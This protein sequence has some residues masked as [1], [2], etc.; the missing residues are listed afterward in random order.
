MIQILGTLFTGGDAF[1][2]CADYNIT[3]LR[4]M[5][6]Q[7]SLTTHAL[8][9]E[10]RTLVTKNPANPDVVHQLFLSVRTINQF[11][12]LL[13]QE[14]LIIPGGGKYS[15]IVIGQNLIRDDPL[16]LSTG[17]RLLAINQRMCK[18]IEDVQRIKG[19]P[20]ADNGCG[21]RIFLRRE[22]L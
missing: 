21:G 5:D 8:S 15:F 7:L 2:H 9:L 6:F 20:L 18:R 16:T 11:C 13:K 10:Q 19:T 12:Y 14:N 3:F 4:R 22:G 1:V 17:G